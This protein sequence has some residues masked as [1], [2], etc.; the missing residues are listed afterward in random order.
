VTHAI[1]IVVIDDHTLFRRGVTSLLAREPRF[2][3]V[4]EAADA[5][6]AS[7]SPPPRA[8]TSSCSTCTCLA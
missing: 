6:E 5:L 1:R 3:V 8:P 7:R 4:G 2:E